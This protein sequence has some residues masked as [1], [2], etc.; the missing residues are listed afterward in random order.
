M[1]SLYNVT[2]GENF[3]EEVALGFPPWEIPLPS[4]VYVDPLSLVAN[5]M[6]F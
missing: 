1:D 5:N 6:E 3:V 4:T 2:C